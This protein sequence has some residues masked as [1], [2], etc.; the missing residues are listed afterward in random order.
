MARTKRYLLLSGS[1]LTND[2][3]FLNSGDWQYKVILNYRLPSLV[4]SF[5]VHMY[6]YIHC[7]AW[8]YSSV[9]RHH[10]TYSANFPF[11]F[12]YSRCLRNIDIWNILMDAYV[13][14]NIFCQSSNLFHLF[15]LF[16]KLNH[17]NTIPKSAHVYSAHLL[18]SF[19]YSLCLPNI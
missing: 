6:M 1:V 11:S 13:L 5:I 14:Q 12:I 17:L 15:T 8:F 16:V 19:I 4:Y 10:K 9:M 18:F 3:S 7:R 2:N